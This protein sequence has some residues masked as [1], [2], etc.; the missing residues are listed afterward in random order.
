MKSWTVTGACGG[1]YPAA[2]P[3]FF[4]DGQRVGV[5]TAL[6]VKIY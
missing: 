5:A 4:K 6:G 1:R 3:V 2:D